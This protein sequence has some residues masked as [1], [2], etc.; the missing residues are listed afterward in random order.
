MDGAKVHFEVYARKNGKAGFLLELATEDRAKA[1]EAAEEML[2]LKR[3]VAVKVTKETMDVATGEFQSV[4]ILNKGEAAKPQSKTA[5]EDAG[6]LCVSPSDLYSAHARERIGRLLEAWLL[7]HRATPFDLLHRPDLVEKLEASGVEIQHAVQKIA[8]P[9]AQAKGVSVH[10]I[11]RGFQ[12]LIEQ[13]IERILKHHRQGAFPDFGRERFGD[14]AARLIDDGD[15]VYKLGVGV[16]CDLQSADSWN[17]KVDRLL[18]LADKAPSE[19]KARALAFQVLEQPLGEI[20]GARAGLTELL[21]ADL[22]LG[23]SLLALARMAACDAVDALVAADP[24]IAR[25]TPPLNGSAARLATWLDS[26]H[27]QTVRS[28]IAKRVLQE[29]T[30]PRRLRPGDPV[31]EIEVMRALAM[32]LTAAVGR[33]LQPEDIREAFS[34]RSE[35]LVTSDF[36]GGYLDQGGSAL[37]DVQALVRLA[38]NVTGGTNKRKAAQ[39]LLSTITGL[40]FERELRDGGEPP[41]AKLLALA[42]LQRSICRV[43]LQDGDDRELC[44]RVGEVGSEIEADAKLIASIGRANTTAGQKLAVLLKMASG[45]AGPSG[46]VAIRAKLEVLRLF[47]A[48]ETRTELA[49]SPEAMTKLKPLMQAVGLAA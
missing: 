19:P 25:L 6:P 21:G 32:V 26:P 15:S 10:E 18:D 14:A 17:D 49:A 45:E 35:S 38:E 24:R 13:T 29:L 31:G 4:S 20:L 23:G 33:V 48:P 1:L 5:V 46:P 2:T 42:E 22:D 37:E 27:F 3:A 30:S 9:E 43:G 12:K 34:Q 39:W 16:A 36:V 8:I 44:D 11:I 28:A 7:R 41:A 40:R 47:K